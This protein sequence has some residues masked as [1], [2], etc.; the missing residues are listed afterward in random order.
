[1]RI[2]ATSVLVLAA[3]GYLRHAYPIPPHSL[4]MLYL[5]ADIIVVAT[6][7][8]TE[9]CE[10][11]RERDRVVLSVSKTLKGAAAKEITVRYSSGMV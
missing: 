8:K 10:D 5:Q 11:F 1:M 7:G 4:R 9:Y 2:L 6:C 3:Q